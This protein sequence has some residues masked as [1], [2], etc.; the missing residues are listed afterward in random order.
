MTGP[1]LLDTGAWLLALAGDEPWATEVEQAQERIVPGLV[2][3]ELDYHLRANRRA[4]H[5]VLADVASGAYR[6]EPPS[7]RDL[8]RARALDEKFCSVELGLVDASIAALAERLGVARLLTIDSDFYVVRVGPRHD[9]AL[10]LV[11]PPPKR[12]GRKRRR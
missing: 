10:E 6:F 8:E 1:L 7:L 11:V 2:L 9:R 3:A 4:A 5:H 12:R